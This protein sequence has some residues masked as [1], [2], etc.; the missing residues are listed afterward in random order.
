MPD[1][2]LSE[3]MA[4]AAARKI[5]ERRHRLLR[6]RASPCWPPWRP[7]TSTPP[8]SVI[9]F[10]TGAIDS[11][12]EEI[13]MAVGDPRVMLGASSNSGLADAFALMQNRPRTGSG[14]RDPGRGPDRQVT[15]TSTPPPSATTSTPRCASPAAAGPA[16]WPPSSTAPSSSCSTSAASS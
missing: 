9:I 14:G 1:Y 3:L 6:H 15:A 12:L 8:S 2:T 11:Q 13:P 7:S 5:N 4:I 16:T 10:E